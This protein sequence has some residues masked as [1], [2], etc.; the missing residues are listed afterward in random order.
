MDQLISTAFSFPTV[1]F[2]V[3]LIV[4]VVYWLIGLIGLVDLD[5]G[6]DVDLDIDADADVSVGGISGMLLTFGLTGVPVTFVISIIVLLCWIVT[7]YAQFYLLTWLPDG[8]LYYVAG[9][10]CNIGIF[11]LSLPVTAVIIRPLRGLFK[12]AEAA[13]SNQLIGL[14]GTVATGT[15][16]DTFGQVK[17]FN[18][19]AELLVDARNDSQH[20]LEQ[21]DKV[22]IIEYQHDSH[23]YV[24][25]PYPQ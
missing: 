23:T 1:T 18:D 24:V 4:V 6:G 11:F 2:T 17:L 8:W 16:T 3:L 22:L 5:F 19:G 10:A 9:L 14:E 15:I 25:A 21:G 7:Y 13:T 12:S 20:Q